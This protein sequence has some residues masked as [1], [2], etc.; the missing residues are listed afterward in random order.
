MNRRYSMDRDLR[1]LILKYI[2]KYEEYRQWYLMEKEKI[3][4]LKAVAY[5]RMPK[6]KTW[7]T[8]RFGR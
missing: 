3:N 6:A 5:D 8:E 1:T 7:W 4:G 2:R